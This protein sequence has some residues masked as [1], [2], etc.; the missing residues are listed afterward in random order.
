MAN[1]RT[2]KVNLQVDYDINTAS[3]E[4]ALNRVAGVSR[5]AGQ[6]MGAAG[7][8]A[9]STANEMLAMGTAGKRANIVLLDTSRL[10]EDS[11]YG[12]RGMSNNLT[13]L[14]LSFQRLQ[15]DAGGSG[16]AIKVL[17]KGLAGPAGLLVAVATLSTLAVTF[18]P[19]L[20]A[21]FGKKN[22]KD[23]EDYKEYVKEINEEVR[24]HLELLKEFK[25]GEAYRE[26]VRYLTQNL[27][28][29]REIRKEIEKQYK[30]EQE[31]RADQRKNRNAGYGGGPINRGIFARG[32]EKREDKARVAQQK[33]QRKIN[34]LTTE[35]LNIR[36]EINLSLIADIERM[37]ERNELL[38]L[39]VAG[40][41]D[42]EIQQ[43]KVNKAKE[44]RN[45]LI[46]SGAAA[47]QIMVAQQVLE[48]EEMQLTILQ[49]AESNELHEER[50]ALIKQE[51]EEYL[52]YLEAVREHGRAQASLQGRGRDP[53]SVEGRTGP[54]EQ[55]VNKEGLSGKERID[56][57]RDEADK[58]Y[59]D[60]ATAIDKARK[61]LE[62]YNEAKRRELALTIERT[63]TEAASEIR[64]AKNAKERG[65]AIAKAIA[66]LIKEIALLKIKHAILKKMGLAGAATGVGGAGGIAGTI[67]TILGTIFGFGGGSNR[68]VSTPFFGSGGQSFGPPPQVNLTI[69]NI[70]DGQVLNET[71]TRVNERNTR[72]G[73]GYIG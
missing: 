15:R 53:G 20:G 1:K 14:V 39:E 5:K 52:A 17:V 63:I 18:G 30:L 6:G 9:G 69:N 50:I 45:V 3:A 59:E 10:V 42:I 11:A 62:K 41:T 7:G 13:P 40:A 29:Q 43:Y 73:T 71:T 54:G 48:N 2:G 68:N 51:K 22:Q 64:A 4:A 65:E 21:M 67:G 33:G 31:A 55:I 16:A 35:E 19:K 38:K 34:E 47:N 46:F 72:L 37:A 58:I 57:L 56:A 32:S 49:N 70:V 66:N 24:K 25:Q 60:E 26:N 23:L 8:A 36:R 12:I 61:A 44:E 28:K 27:A